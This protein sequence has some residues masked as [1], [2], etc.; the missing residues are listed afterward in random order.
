[1]DNSVSVSDE[2]NSS[3]ATLAFSTVWL[4]TGANRGMGFAYVSQV[5][6]LSE[7]PLR[8]R[9]TLKPEW[10][11]G[12][13]LYKCL[14]ILSKPRTK[15][16]AAARP[17]DDCSELHALSNVHGNRMMI[18]PLELSDFNTVQATAKSHELNG[19]V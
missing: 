10:N 5:K 8:A 13:D 15:V 4:V 7:A 2:H 14:Q 17:A 1:M 3:D 11:Y 6:A 19:L 16:I 18:V 9:T 12:P